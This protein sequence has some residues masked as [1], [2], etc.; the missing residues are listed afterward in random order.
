MNIGK[1]IQQIRKSKGIKQNAL[2]E[3]MGITPAYLSMI[4]TGTKVNIGLQFVET[5]AFALD[6]TPLYILF[7]SIEA[8]DTNQNVGAAE[9]WEIIKPAILKIV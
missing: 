2:A 8:D 5:A 6:V 7:E 1:A 9:I 4:E 3:K